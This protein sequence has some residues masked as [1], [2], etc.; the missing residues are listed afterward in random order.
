MYSGV[1]KEGTPHASDAAP[2]TLALNIAISLMPD[3]QRPAALSD[4]KLLVME[5][6]GVFA[7]MSGVL[8]RILHEGGRIMLLIYRHLNHLIKNQS[9]IVSLQFVRVV[10]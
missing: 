9:L 10:L 6:S 8:A 1:A 4:T 5:L 3:S 2:S 7:D